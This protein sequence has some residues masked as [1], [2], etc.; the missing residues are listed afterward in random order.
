MKKAFLFKDNKGNVLFITIVIIAV[1]IFI[2]AIV[3]EWHR[4]I[5]I[6]D[7]FDVEITRALKSS[8]DLSLK[9][10]YRKDG[11]SVMDSKKAEDE[12]YNYLF[13]IMKLDE[14][15]KYYES[16]KFIYS[17]NIENIKFVSEPPWIYIDG[18]IEVAPV[19]FGMADSMYEINF[20]KGIHNM[21][22]NYE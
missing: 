20:S 12:F 8:I 14:N 2:T 18:Y 11:V 21:R 7:N 17:L 13:E 9:D 6:A 4:T 3:V 19:L 16:G 15:F 1:I 5:T 22:L 10:E